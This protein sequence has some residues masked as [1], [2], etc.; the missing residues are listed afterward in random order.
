MDYVFLY[1]HTKRIEWGYGA[2]IDTQDDRTT[3]KFDDGISRTIK[4]DHIHLMV[5]VELDEPQGSE[6]R[7]RLA[8]SVKSAAAASSPARKL[9]A[10]KKAAKRAADAKAAEPKT[11]EAN[12]EAEAEA[13]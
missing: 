7:K 13:E 8:R 3:F 6:V 4:R 2:V 1:Q 10:K 9:A 12:T 11:V 5:Q